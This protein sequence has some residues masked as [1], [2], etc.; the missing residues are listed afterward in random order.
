MFVRVRA[1]VRARAR[2]RA[3]ATGTG[4]EEG[5]GVEGADEEAEP[6]QPPQHAVELL[7]DLV[8]AMRGGNAAVKIFQPGPASFAESS[9]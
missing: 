7:E 6:G 3:R 4:Q 1:C 2:A 5:E 8:D 9:S